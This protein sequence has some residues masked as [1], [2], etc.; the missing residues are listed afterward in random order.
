MPYQLDYLETIP[1]LF[2]DAV[3]KYNH[4]DL[5]A[6][7]QDQEFTYITYQEVR[8]QVELIG[9][10]LR[11]LG[12]EAGDR[13]AILS[14]NKPEWIMT[15]Y[16]CAHF[17]IITVPVYPTIPVDQVAY[18]LNDSGASLVFVSNRSQGEKILELSDR[19]PH[20]QQMI[21]Y[22]EDQGFDGDWIMEYRSLLTEGRR[23]LQSVDYTLEDVGEERAKDDLWTI[24]YTSGTTGMP[25]GVMLSHF[26]LTSNVQ[27]ATEAIGIYSGKRWLSFL[28]LSHSFERAVSHIAFWVGSSVY[29]ME[30]I[31]SILEA[32]RVF[33][34]HYF[35]AVPRLYEKLYNGVLTKVQKGSFLKRLIFKW[36]SRVGEEACELY[37]RYGEQPAGWLGLKYGIAHKLVFSTIQEVFGGEVILSISGGAPFPA[38]IGKFFTATGV[39]IAEGYGLTE[40]T[41]VTNVSRPSHIKFG[42][43]G[44]PL[45]DVEM[46]SAPDG[47][48][49]FRGPNRMQGYYNQPEATDEIID[50]EGWLHTGDIGE[51]DEDNY[52]TITDRKKN[53]IVTSGG[54]NVA[55]VPL[56]KQL[57]SSR[58]IEQAIVLG[59]K[60][61]HLSAL[62]IPNRET[63]EFW[64]KSHG[65]NYREYGDLITSDEIRSLIREEIE[66]QLR[67]FASFEQIKRFTL[68][69]EPLTVEDGE[70]TPTLKVKRRVI[71]EKYGDLIS[72]M[73]PNHRNSGR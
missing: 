56:E 14:E 28:P 27:G 16:A 67:D 13:V 59:D 52:L 29:V 55:P 20:L 30:S 62:I 45:P 18:I 49:L 48:I 6:Q 3:R 36:A 8:D 64:A 33:K 19:L 4:W 22:D 42:T 9:M 26:N 54:K 47:E 44:P 72:Q 12:Y 73:Y 69:E 43:V 7:K 46:K 58:Y 34:P 2:S 25:K 63:V 57:G 35:A 10:G 38:E 68:L 40:M 11:A 65:M 51:I 39:T 53:L 17:G 32:L 61:D 21:V 24:I 1:A 5:Y 15:D 60:R 37:I 31:E 71:E 70:L 41:P 66:T 50:E 23:F